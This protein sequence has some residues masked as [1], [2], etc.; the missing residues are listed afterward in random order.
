M[1]DVDQCQCPAAGFCRTLG[2]NM[3]H[4]RWQ[5]CQTS[6]AYREM[7]RR[8]AS[9]GKYRGKVYPAPIVVGKPAKPGKPCG[10]DRRKRWLNSI[11][12]G[13][14]TAVEVLTTVTG[15]KWLVDRWNVRN[16]PERQNSTA[17]DGP[18]RD[19]SGSDGV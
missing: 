5:E 11:V 14:G 15:V 8:E 4:A 7:F 18:Q 1:P 2:R 6:E 3:S 19:P 9:E 16:D 17:Q 10:C 12:P 13:L